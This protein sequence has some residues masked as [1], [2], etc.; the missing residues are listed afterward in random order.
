MTHDSERQCRTQGQARSSAFE[1]D[2]QE[3]YPNLGSPGRFA[4]ALPILAR[5]SHSSIAVVIGLL[6]ET[7]TAVSTEPEIVHLRLTSSNGTRLAVVGE[8]WPEWEFWVSDGPDG[9]PWIVTR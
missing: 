8:G 6:G 3:G 9:G 1:A 2:R 5:A 4:S 7:V